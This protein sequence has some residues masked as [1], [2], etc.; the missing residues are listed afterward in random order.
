M[1]VI[2]KKF[3]STLLIV[4]VS[5]VCIAQD[6]NQ[7]EKV[8]TLKETENTYLITSDTANEDSPLPEKKESTVWLFVR[9]VIVL[10]FVI[11]CIYG[12]SLLLKNATKSKN[13]NDLYLRKTAHLQLSPG[14]SVQVI[15]LQN[16]AYII[17]VTDNSINVL[18]E[19][20]DEDLI[21]AMNINA[22]KAPQG[23]PRDFASILSAFNTVNSNTQNNL[24]KQRE[25]LH[26]ASLLNDFDD[27]KQ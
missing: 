10:A 8:N 16:K 2:T 22:D 27:R 25:R 9:M 21:N 15:T 3:I 24:K 13:S 4:F 7:I 20:T 18:G 23:K 17:G 1:G 14:K 12:F 11:G 5:F 26:S 6:T 19:V